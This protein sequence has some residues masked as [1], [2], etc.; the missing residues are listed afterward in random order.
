MSLGSPLYLSSSWGQCIRKTILTGSAPN[1]VGV[2]DGDVPLINEKNLPF[3][4]ESSSCHE[5]IRELIP[6]FRPQWHLPSYTITDEL[7][8][9]TSDSA[10]RVSDTATGTTPACSSIL[11]QT[12]HGQSL[13]EPY[14]PPQPYA[15]PSALRVVREPHANGECTSLPPGSMRRSCPTVPTLSQ[16][17]QQR[18]PS[19][20]PRPPTHR[21]KT[22][23]DNDPPPAYERLDPK[24]G[25]G[26][27]DRPIVR[28]LQ[29]PKATTAKACRDVV[30]CVEDIPQVMKDVQQQNRIRRARTK[31][32]WLE[33]HN[34]M[35]SQERLLKHEL[36][37]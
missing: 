15:H 27:Q 13:H 3:D 36:R 21:P 14:P 30:R 34:F 8:R 16:P 37:G 23:T 1:R 26:R 20:T 22:L 25:V 35:S 12:C 10:R 6:D 32:L 19:A 18:D 5:S 33:K 28:A 11:Q 9:L 4:T 24:Q 31:M 7:Y 17:C 2:E 29:A